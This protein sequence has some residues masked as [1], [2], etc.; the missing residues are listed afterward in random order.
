MRLKKFNE[1]VGSESISWSVTCIDG[2]RGENQV[3]CVFSEQIYAA[4]FIIKWTNDFLKDESDKH[5]SFYNKVIQDG[6]VPECGYFEPFFDENGKSNFFHE[7][8]SF[9]LK[10][11]EDWLRCDKFH[12]EL[13][14]WDYPYLL[15]NKA[16]YYKSPYKG[17]Y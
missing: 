9:K 10:E 12:I 15:I 13:A 6:F 17:K 14:G 1:S 7:S 4:D 8:S 5:Y 16:I 2:G 11:N 3:L